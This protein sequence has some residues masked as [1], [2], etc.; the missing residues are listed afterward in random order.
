[1]KYEIKGRVALVTGANRGIGLEI[2]EALVR[3]GAAKVYAAVRNVSSAQMLVEAHGGVVEAVQI[4]LEYPDTVAA[5]AAIAD[6]VDIVI[7]NA[8]VLRSAAPLEPH[9]IDEF[10]FELEIN[11]FGLIRMAQAFSPV[12]ARNGGG[13]F[14]QLN[15]LASMKS[16]AGFATYCASKAAS[17]SITQALRDVL[18]EQG[19]RVVSVHPGPIAT[20]MATSAGL[21]EIAEPAAV[22]AEAIIHALENEE[23]HVF[24]DSMAQ[25]IGA[26]YQ[27]FAENVVE[28][29][30]MAE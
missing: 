19:T 13:A 25:Q 5:A 26:V 20:D 16:F 30:L 29:D 7:N 10:K 18:K 3:S 11:A 23:F 21:D 9:A 6:D 15:S 14:V 22:V 28:A 8:G 17:Y 12:L 2:V 4:D 27:P 1:M 24:P